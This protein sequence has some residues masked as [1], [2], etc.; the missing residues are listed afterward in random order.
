MNVTMRRVRVTIF[1][2]Q[3]Q[4]CICGLSYPAYKAPA[5]CS[6]VRCFGVIFLHVI[7]LTARFSGKMLLNMKYGFW[8]SLQ[9]RKTSFSKKTLARYYK[10]SSVFM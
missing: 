3:K 10:C 2:V 4:E 6:I 5:L 8:F 9:P 1:V 7:S